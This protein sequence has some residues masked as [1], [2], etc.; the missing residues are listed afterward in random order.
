MQDETAGN[1]PETTARGGGAPGACAPDPE[2][3]R[4]HIDAS[5]PSGGFL[6]LSIWVNDGQVYH[7]Y[8]TSAKRSRHDGVPYAGDPADWLRRLA[9]LNVL[10]WEPSYGDHPV[11][12]GI[13]WSLDF[14]AQGRPAMLSRGDNAFPANWKEFV[15]LLDE[16]VPESRLTDELGDGSAEEPE[17]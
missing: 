12:G 5:L 8:R 2:L 13:Q 4:M 10:S 11:I 17:E 9:A 15:G 16:A 14:N 7:S 6:H 3:V 1:S